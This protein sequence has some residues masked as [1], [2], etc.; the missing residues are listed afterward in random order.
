VLQC[1]VAAVVARIACFISA[2][3]DSGYQQPLLGPAVAGR[4]PW[5]KY[6]VIGSSYV[7]A[8]FLGQKSLQ[9]ISFPTQVIVKSC[10]MVPVMVAGALLHN[11]KYS[12][13]DY[14]RVVMVTVG[15]VVF[16]FFK[17][18]A[19][20]SHASTAPQISL[21]NEAL[22]LVLAFS[23]LVLDAFVSPNQQAVTE[24][25][26]SSPYQN[27][28]YSNVWGLVLPLCLTV[29]ADELQ[30]AA[31]AVM[32]NPA[33]LFDLV[34]FGLLSAA[35]QVFIFLAMDSFGSLTLVTITTTRKFFT[36]LA[37]IVIYKH[38]VSAGQVAGMVMVFG[39]LAWKELSHAM[40]K[41]K[42]KKH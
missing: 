10:K 14:V 30:P 3:P 23:S 32:A 12:A 21:W 18:A 8:M 7:G 19:K 33:L 29:A 37:S 17:D 31:A 36:V 22:G 15:I 9:F 13:A 20:A 1:V 34:C 28:Y 11:K 4:V 42:S 27:M 16:T 5:R 2:Q 25:Y 35:G 6:A 39:G 40:G 41:E 26:Q 24:E 38:S